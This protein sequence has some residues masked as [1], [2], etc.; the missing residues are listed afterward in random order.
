MAIKFSLYSLDAVTHQFLVKHNITS[1]QTTKVPS[2]RAAAFFGDDIF[3]QVVFYKN[4]VVWDMLEMGY[5]VLFQDA[6]VVW[7]A[8][9]RPVLSQFTE[10][11][12]FMYDGPN[13]YQQ[14]LYI[15]SGFFLVKNNPRSHSLWRAAFL[16]GHAFASQQ[17]MLEKLLVHYY[18]NAGLTIHVLD[19]R[20]ANGHHLVT[21]HHKVP[22]NWIVFH[23]SWTRNLT[24]KIVRFKSQR[25]WYTGC[26]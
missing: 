26:I 8:D 23:T 14:P 24:V 17:P 11:M 7:R 13:K 2:Q 20:F 12:I 25:L 16:N 5:N 18:F 19:D 21:N 22:D 15:N 1:W 3:E 9:P 10:D 6:D 4:A